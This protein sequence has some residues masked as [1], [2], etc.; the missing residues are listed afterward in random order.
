MSVVLKGACACVN[1][2]LGLSFELR[3]KI[4][5]SYNYYIS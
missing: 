4:Y 2:F 5:S 1:L 3:V